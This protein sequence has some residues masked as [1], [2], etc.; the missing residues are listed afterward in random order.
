MNILVIIS[1]GEGS[2][3]LQSYATSEVTHQLDKNNNRVSVLSICRNDY[4]IIPSNPYVIS[5][6][7][8]GN[9][10]E[11]PADN[12]S[13]NIDD[14]IYTG[15]GFDTCCK[16]CSTSDLIANSGE[17]QPFGTYIDKLMSVLVTVDSF[18]AD[19]FITSCATA[20]IENAY[21]DN[22]DK[23]VFSITICKDDFNTV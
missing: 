10:E 20:L 1:S 19:G 11:I 14:N 13:T 18:E 6:E 15:C 22:N 4:D 2:T 12:N 7:E 16:S 3:F 21:M 23:T 5:I 8:D 9:K 17:D